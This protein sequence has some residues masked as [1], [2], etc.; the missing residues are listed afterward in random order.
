M[1]NTHTSSILFGFCEGLSGE[2]ESPVVDEL[3]TDL[4]GV[5]GVWPFSKSSTGIPPSEKEFTGENQK[6]CE[7]HV[8]SKGLL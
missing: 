4:T 3:A 6:Q 1:T 8:Y 5:E 2:G 7:H